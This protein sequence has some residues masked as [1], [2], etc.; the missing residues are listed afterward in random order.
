M[1]L[2]RIALIEDNA[3]SRRLVQTILGDSYQITEYQAGDEGLDGVRHSG[4]DLVILDISLP[5]MNGVEVVQRLKADPL[6]ARIPVIALTA[7]AMVG[8][9]ARFL[10]AGF[11]DYI[12]KPIDNLALLSAVVNRLIQG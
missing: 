3:D 5:G 1:S 9:R 8:D 10:A 12:S 11:D 2:N 6:T 7:H 4:A